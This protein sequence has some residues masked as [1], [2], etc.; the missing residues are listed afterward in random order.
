MPTVTNKPIMMGVVMLS[1]IMLSVFMLSV[2]NKP[3]MTSVFMLSVIM[4]GVVM[5]NVVAPSNNLPI[6]MF[7]AI[8]RTIGKCTRMQL[9]PIIF[10]YTQTGP[11][12]GP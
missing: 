9:F 10:L 7:V 11:H 5:L 1:V 8:S 4:L 12:Q 3:I 2:A 6:K